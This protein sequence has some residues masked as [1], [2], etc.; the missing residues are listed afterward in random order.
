MKKS[1]QKSN[2]GKYQQNKLPYDEE[3]LHT[4]LIDK[5]VHQFLDDLGFSFV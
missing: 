2:K 4:Y 3:V 5:I 1:M